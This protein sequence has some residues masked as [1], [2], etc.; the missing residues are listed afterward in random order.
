MVF[1]FEF[2][3]E[4]IIKAKSKLTLYGKVLEI[5]LLGLSIPQDTY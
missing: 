1:S 3:T 5:Q 2:L 4:I